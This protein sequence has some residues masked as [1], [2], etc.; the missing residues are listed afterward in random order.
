MPSIEIVE[1]RIFDDGRERFK[2]YPNKWQII[3]KK[4]NG[5]KLILRNI[6]YPDIIIH[7]ISAWKTVK[8]T[9]ENYA[10]PE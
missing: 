3:E 1:I 8:I 4:Y 5:G 6:A 2:Q 9:N 10:T 7:T